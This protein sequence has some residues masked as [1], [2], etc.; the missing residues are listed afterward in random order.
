[1]MSVYMQE[2]PLLLPVCSTNEVK[3]HVKLCS[4]GHYYLHPLFC[5]MF[6]PIQEEQQ[7]QISINKL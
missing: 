6:N 7:I 3:L 5:G 1:M 4:S 2:D